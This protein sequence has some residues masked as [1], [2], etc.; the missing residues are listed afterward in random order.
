[1]T[2]PN[3][4]RRLPLLY[5]LATLL[6]VLVL[7]YWTRVVLIPVALAILLTFLLDPVVRL[8]QRPGLPRT[9][10]VILVVVVAFALLGSIGWVVSGQLTS[11][12]N[13]LPHHTENLQHKLTDLRGMGR[14]GII[15]KVQQTIEAVLREPRQAP[16]PR[17]A[18]PLGTEPE[19]PVPVVVQPPSVL[20]QLPSLLEPLASAGLVLVLV[21]FMLLKPSDLRNR[22]IRLAGYSQLT[23]ATKALDDAG[24]R[25]SRYLLMQ[26]IVNG[27]FG[28]AVG[29]GIFLIGVPYAILW[30]FLA[31][32]LR[33]IPYVGPVV[34]AFFPSALSLAVFPGWGQPIMVISLML[35]LELASSMVMEPFLYGKSAGVSEV[36]LLVAVAFWTWLWGPVGLLL[37]TPLTVCLS[38]LSKYIPPLDFLNTLIGDEPVLDLPTRYYQRL[39]AKDDDEAAQIVE[40]YGETRAPE[41]V[42]DDIV[43]PALT[44]AK[45]DR[46]QDTITPADLHFVLHATRTIVDS[47]ELRQSQALTAAAGADAPTGEAPVATTSPLVHIVGCPARDDADALALVMFQHLLDPGRYALEIAS[48]EMLTAEVVSLVGEQGIDLI[49]IAALPPGATTP[50]R[51]LCKR[52][53][54]RFPACKIMVGRWGWTGEGEAN[55]ALLRAAGADEVS[56]T[57]R[58][59]CTHVRQW[60]LL[61]SSPTPEGAPLVGLG[62]HLTDGS[63]TTP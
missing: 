12:A 55:Q 61:D 9:P 54:A 45:R 4:I 15:E 52:L 29:F 62:P 28:L 53:R 58:E 5:V 8:L 43:V 56:M 6:V 47:V 20:W 22:L 51:Y 14:G 33:F 34:A 40:T 57:L 2:M 7:L 3:D 31:A 13:D 25:I 32:V 48:A 27:S 59:S 42:Y 63:S 10:A 1:M 23:T 26:G 60:G 16:P 18:S 41:D 37:A 49:C 35:A 36:A 46:E 50:T 38:V 19:R 21:I 39:L 30:G 24:Q 44:M 17:P 11:L